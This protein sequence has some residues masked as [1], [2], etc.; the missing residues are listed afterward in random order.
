MTVGDLIECLKLVDPSLP[1]FIPGWGSADGSWVKIDYAE[2]APMAPSESMF[3]LYKVKPE[4]AHEFSVNS[5]EEWQ[6][7]HGFKAVIIS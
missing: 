2:E 4:D 7:Q 3:R 5:S 6:K 1:V